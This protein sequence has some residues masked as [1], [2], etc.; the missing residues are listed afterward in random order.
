MCVCVCMHTLS[1]MAGHAN[2]QN[3]SRDKNMKSVSSLIYDTSDKLNLKKKK[4]LCIFHW[5]TKF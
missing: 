1:L 5:L 2:L 4:I 3:K